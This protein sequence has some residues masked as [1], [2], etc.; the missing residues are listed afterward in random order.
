MQLHSPCRVVSTRVRGKWAKPSRTVPSFSVNMPERMRNPFR[1]SFS[2]NSGPIRTSSSASIFAT[3]TAKGPA[4]SSERRCRYL[5]VP[6]HQVQLQVLLCDGN[7]FGVDIYCANTPRTEFCRGN[8][9]DT[10]A[11]ADIEEIGRERRVGIAERGFMEEYVLQYFKTEPGCWMCTGSEG[12]AGVKFK[13]YGVIG[14]VP[15]FPGGFDD[16]SLAYAGWP[17]M[18][19]PVIGPVF[20]LDV[21][22][23][24]RM[25]DETGIGRSVHGKV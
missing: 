17:E 2:T 4:T 10:G 12:H 24:R 23:C 15:L 7:R 3:I 20:F 5:D 25:R 9:E 11:G 19:F 13:Y 1:R 18:F 8:G 16:H 14:T 6:L 21:G 22:D